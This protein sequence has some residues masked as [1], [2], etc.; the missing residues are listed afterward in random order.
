M[1]FSEKS[2]NGAYMSQ[3][4]LVMVGEVQFLFYPRLP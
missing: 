1:N 3:K 2:K 4:K